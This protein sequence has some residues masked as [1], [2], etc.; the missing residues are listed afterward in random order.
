VII[1]SRRN[2]LFPETVE[3]QSTVLEGYKNKLLQWTVE[4]PVYFSVSMLHEIVSYY[5]LCIKYL[6]MFTVVCTSCLLNRWV[7]GHV[8]WVMGRFLCGSVGRRSLLWGSGG[9]LERSQQTRG[10]GPG[11]ALKA[12]SA[13]TNVK[14]LPSK[15]SNEARWHVAARGVDLCCGKCAHCHHR[16]AAGDHAT[17]TGAQTRRD[18]VF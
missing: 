12:G 16:A 11:E 7:T 14:L 6:E 15:S 18:V 10:A 9:F 5:T 13:A 8:Y 4:I 1:T 17:L 2:M 3:A